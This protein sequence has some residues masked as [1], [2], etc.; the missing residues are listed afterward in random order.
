MQGGGRAGVVG[1]HGQRY[2]SPWC[3]ART[4]LRFFHRSAPG[5]QSG[6]AAALTFKLTTTQDERGG[7][8][9]PRFFGCTSFGG[10]PGQ[11]ASGFLTD[12]SRLAA[13][14]SAPGGRGGGSGNSRL[15][16]IPSVNGLNFGRTV[17][18]FTMPEE[19]PHLLD[20][21]EHA[22]TPPAHSAPK[23][24]TAGTARASGD[25]GDDDVNRA[26]LSICT[27]HPRLSVGLLRRLGKALKSYGFRGPM[28]TR[29]LDT[30]HGPEPCCQNPHY[31]RGKRPEINRPPPHQVDD[32]RPST[33]PQAPARQPRPHL[34]N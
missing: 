20:V 28:S 7:Y 15:G 9:P 31:L 26:P 14:S 34:R 5:A 8:L 25:E 6:A 27:A 4:I 11:P 32:A 21:V 24:S 2:G 12:N 29:A 33:Q 10:T 23:P 30:G 3:Y 16:A 19:K 18:A 17:L 1:L 22:K 13:S